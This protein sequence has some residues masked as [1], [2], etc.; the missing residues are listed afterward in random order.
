MGPQF[1]HACGR[2]RKAYSVRV[3]AE[4]GEQ[5]G[6]RFKRIQQMKCGNRPA[7]AVCLLAIA[8]NH[9]RRAAITLHHP[10]SCDA[11]YAAVPALAINHNAK[12]L[13][14]SRV[15]LRNVM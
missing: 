10:R 2:Q 12:R 3:S 13:P 7:R 9:Q 1:R 4:A 6:A 8:R 11:D 14:Q 5:S 15:F